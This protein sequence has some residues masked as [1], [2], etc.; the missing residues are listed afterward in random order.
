LTTIM[1]F[2]EIR[3]RPIVGD[4]DPHQHEIVQYL[5]DSLVEMRK[6]VEAVEDRLDLMTT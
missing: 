2:Q 4:P 1:K 5:S 6:M 3:L